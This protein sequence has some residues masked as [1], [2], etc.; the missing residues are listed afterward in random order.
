MSPTPS[1]KVPKSLK[2]EIREE[3][4]QDH[5]IFRFHKFK[6]DLRKPL[7]FGEGKANLRNTRPGLPL[8]LRAQSFHPIDTM[9]T[10]I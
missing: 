6:I 10:D 9:N 1:K 3:C 8:T 5:L 4:I 7:N 2:T